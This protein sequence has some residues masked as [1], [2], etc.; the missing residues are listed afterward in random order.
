MCNLIS[1]LSHEKATQEVSKFDKN[2]LKHTETQEK[3]GWKECK[4]V[5]YFGVVFLAVF[6]L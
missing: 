6:I 2:T 1:A 4:A 3:S 5:L